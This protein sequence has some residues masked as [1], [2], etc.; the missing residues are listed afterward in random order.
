MRLVMKTEKGTARSLRLEGG[1]GVCA[2]R[3][4]SL[5]MASDAQQCST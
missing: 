4:A 2:T 3:I 5:L 1:V